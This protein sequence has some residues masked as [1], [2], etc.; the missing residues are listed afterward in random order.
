MWRL[1][2]INPIIL[3]IIL[4]SSLFFSANSV[5]GQTISL[6][7]W[8]PLL[9]TVIQPG[10]SITQV[11][12][13]TNNGDDTI[14][15]ASIVPF[16]ASGQS[17]QIKLSAIPSPAIGWFSLQNAD[18]DSLPVS[19]PLK[20][21]QTQELV[22]K[23]RVPETAPEGDYYLSFLF[24]STTEGLIFGSGANTQGSIAANILI[25]VSQSGIINPTAKIETF[26][27]PKIIDSFSPIPFTLKLKN[28]SPN[29][30]KAVGQIEI[31]NSFKGLSATLPLREDNILAHSIRQLTS[32]TASGE[33]PI[34][35]W[36]PAFALGRYQAVATITPQN[37][38]NKISQKI[39]FYVL[40]YKLTL[41]L[42]IAF[43]LY[44]LTKNKL[45][46]KFKLK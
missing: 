7:V 8:P 39:S 16:E 30:L 21:G 6:S 9:E 46:S 43:A 3:S 44:C 41:G 12:K 24:N 32:E 4:L 20:S 28:T 37:S 2:V 18:L 13:L 40:P 5:I 38:T 45:Q 10:K 36:K 17:G 34:I 11:Y 15:N 14:I 22:L 42:I 26:S 1:R 29:R 25:T 31:F 35:V 33:T 27:A 23:L 19:F